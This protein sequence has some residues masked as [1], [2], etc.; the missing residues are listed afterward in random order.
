MNEVIAEINKDIEPIPEDFKSL[1][2][3]PSALLSFIIKSLSF[4]LTSDNNFI[5]SEEKPTGKDKNL[6][7]IKTGWPYAIGYYIDGE[8]KMDY[9]IS[10]FPVNIIFLHPPINPLKEGITMLTDSVLESYGMGNTVAT[11]SARMRWYIFSPNQI[12]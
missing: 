7:W 8:W 6:I 2:E 4:S 5:K 3:S 12:T 11:A 9:S 1:C 10:G